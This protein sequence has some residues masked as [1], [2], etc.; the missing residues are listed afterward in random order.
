MK[1]EL[2]RRL[3]LEVRKSL[4]KDLKIV[5]RKYFEKDIT[6]IVSRGICAN[7]EKLEKKHD[8]YEAMHLLMGELK[9]PLAVFW[10]YTRGFKEWEPRAYMALFLAEYLKDTIK[11]LKN[12]DKNQ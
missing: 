10:G 3:T 11:E 12:A 1:F 6:F 5:A 9:E 2:D 7:L 4:Q 8:V